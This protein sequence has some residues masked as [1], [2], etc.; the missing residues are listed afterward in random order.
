[1]L[2][3]LKTEVTRKKVVYALPTSRSGAKKSSPLLSCQSPTAVN[4]Q[5]SETRAVAR[6]RGAQRS[7]GERATTAARAEK[8]RRKKTSAIVPLRASVDQERDVAASSV[9]AAAGPAKMSGICFSSA[10]ATTRAP[11]ASTA[12][13]STR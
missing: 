1:M 10:P 5:A 6:A 9:N 12:A 8:G 4:A 3:S 2:G 7:K 11:N 13:A